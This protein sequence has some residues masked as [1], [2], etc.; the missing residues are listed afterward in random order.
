MSDS[1]PRGSW[2]TGLVSTRSLRQVP[3][4]RRGTIPGLGILPPGE[5][6]APDTADY[7]G[8]WL[9]VD[10]AVK[11]KSVCSPIGGTKTGKPKRL[12]VGDWVE[13]NVPRNLRLRG[14]PLFTNPRTG[15]PYPW[16]RS[17]LAPCAMPV[18]RACGCTRE[19]STRSQLT[20]SAAACLSACCSASLGTR[21]FSRPVAM[22]SSP[23][24]R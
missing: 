10:K 5:E 8:G 17:G 20:R 9:T 21:R 14:G 7:H 4:R 23:S 18:S 15:R 22:R 24:P 2:P 19:R 1:S 3:L 12:P 11:G 13:R 6:R 16:A